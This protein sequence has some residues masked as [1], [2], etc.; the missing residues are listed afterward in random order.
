MSDVPFTAHVF[1]WLPYILGVVV[2]YYFE[3]RSKHAEPLFRLV[4]DCNA[5]CFVHLLDKIELG[6]IIGNEQIIVPFDLELIAG[7]LGPR[8]G[9]HIVSKERLSTMLRLTLLTDCTA[10][11]NRLYVFIDILPVHRL[12]HE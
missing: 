6:V 7:H 4:C 8:C 11:H 10:F 12:A 9:W 3:W 1:V 2:G 5:G